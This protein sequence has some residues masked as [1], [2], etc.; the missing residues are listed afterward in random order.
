MSILEEIRRKQKQRHDTIYCNNTH[1]RNIINEIDGI[2]TTSRADNLQVS[3]LDII[4]HSRFPCMIMCKAGDI[5]PQ[6]NDHK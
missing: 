2:H 6:P 1:R 4:T 5:F 3:G